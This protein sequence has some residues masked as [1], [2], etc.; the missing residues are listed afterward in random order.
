[1]VDWNEGAATA[2]KNFKNKKRVYPTE[3]SLLLIDYL[4]ER[5]T[6]SISELCKFLTPDFIETTFGHVTTPVHGP[7]GV[8]KI[9]GWYA[10]DE[11]KG[12]Y[13]VYPEFVLAWKAQ[14]AQNS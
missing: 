9:G 6:V 3:F 8:P 10:R 11:I 12:I 7:G 1:M 13:L 2:I 4:V 14:R 5:K